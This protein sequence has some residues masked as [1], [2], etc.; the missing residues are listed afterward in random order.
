MN[1]LAQDNKGRKGEM[2][3]GMFRILKDEPEGMKPKRVLEKLA[4]I[5]VPTEY[6][7]G[8]FPS[9]GQRFSHIARFA[10]VD[11][12]KAG[13]MAKENNKW[14]VTPAGLEALEKYQDPLEFQK[15]VNKLY[16]SWSKSKKQVSENG[17][18]ENEIIQEEEDTDK[19]ASVTF[20]EA[21]EQAQESID[22]YLHN[23]DGYDFQD[24]VSDLLT[25]MGYHVIW[26]SPPGKDGGTDIL[27]YTDPL[28][29]HGPR[30]KVQAKQQQKSVSEPELKSFMANIG[31]NDSGIYFCTG[32]FTSDAHKYARI[33]ETKRIMLV[34]SVMLVK[35]W[36]NNMAKLDDRAWQR[37]PL[38]PIY[39]LTP[40]IK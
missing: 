11:A 30:I 40:K 9:G 17:K 23:L 32:G 37:L 14:F 12:M 7:K 18:S 33:Q 10:T 29:T 21:Q 35:L 39:F 4:D 27:A 34:D 1:S 3:Q 28:G 8:F 5:L 22:N 31:Q 26:V 13:W 25:A 38:T 19:S 36:I 16:Q 15:R 6:E 2:L 24:L 20:D